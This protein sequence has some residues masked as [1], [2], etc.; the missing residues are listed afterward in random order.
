MWF[1]LIESARKLIIC[2]KYHVNQINCKEGIG[3]GWIDPTTPPP[4]SSRVHV[5]FFVRL[6]AILGLRTLFIKYTRAMLSYIFNYR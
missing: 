1:R 6:L 5:T 4:P 2:T 3:G